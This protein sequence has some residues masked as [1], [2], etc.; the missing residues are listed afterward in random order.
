MQLKKFAMRI[1]LSLAWTAGSVQG[2]PQA[3][4]QGTSAHGAS[5][6]T[7]FTVSFPASRS[8]AALDGRIVLLLSRDFTRE[9]RTHVAP[10]EPLSAPYLFGLNVDGM[11]PGRP[12]V[13]DDTAFGWPSRQLSKVPSGDYLVQ[14]VLNRYETFH[15]AD[16]RVLKLPPDKGE[17]LPSPEIC[18]RRPC[19]CMSI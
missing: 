19:V 3:G 16:G 2:A 9:P 15:L 18:I 6:A 17:G 12:V 14:A 8:G 11:A 7:S 1:V 4:A 5:G 10:N 13:L